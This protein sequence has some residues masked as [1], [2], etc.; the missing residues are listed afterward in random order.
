MAGID[1]LSLFLM[2]TKNILIFQHLTCDSNKINIDMH[3]KEVM[4]F[5]NEEEY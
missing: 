1:I 5:I 2:Q 3:F 4:K